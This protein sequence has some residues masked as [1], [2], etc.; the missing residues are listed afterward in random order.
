VDHRASTG[1]FLRK[2]AKAANGAAAAAPSV[3]QPQPQHSTKAAAAAAAAEEGNQGQS[4]PQYTLQLRSFSRKTATHLCCLCLPSDDDKEH[5]HLVRE[6]LDSKILHR[7]VQVPISRVFYGRQS[8]SSDSSAD[9][10]HTSAHIL[11]CDYCLRVQ[12]STV[13]NTGLRASER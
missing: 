3:Q 2:G 10:N 5:D 8:H 9:I 4:S 1:K 13:E 6:G 7:N 11:L 12:F